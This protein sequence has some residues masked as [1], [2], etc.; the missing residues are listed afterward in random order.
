[1]KQIYFLL[2]ITFCALSAQA[3]TPY[4]LMGASYSQDFN[5]LVS[6]GESDLSTMPGWSIDETGGGGNDN[7]SLFANNGGSNSGDTKSYGM[8]STTER[9]LGSVSSGSC[10]SKYGMAMMNM[11]GSGI[12]AIGITYTGEQWR[13]GSATR[14]DPDTLY[15]EYSLNASDMGDTSATWIAVPAL[16]FL[17]IQYNQMAS[18]ALDGNLAANKMNITGSIP[19]SLANGNTIHLRWRDNN[20]YSSDD[21]LAIDDFSLTVS[22]TGGPLPPTALSFDPADNAVNIDPT[23]SSVVID[24]DQAV[25]AGTGDITIKNLTDA[26]QQTIAASMATFSGTE[27]TI[28]GVMLSSQKDYAIQID[29]NSFDAS[30]VKYLGIYNDTQWNFST[31]FP[32]ALTDL[33]QI[34]SA[35]VVNASVL[36][37]KLLEAKT[38]SLSL[39]DINGRILSKQLEDVGAGQN[40]IALPTA[41]F[42]AGVYIL[43][44]EGQGAMNIKFVK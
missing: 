3:Q 6:S 21:G 17:S 10:Q 1:M 28:P 39:I 38:L 18:N 16:D 31:G 13:M 42:P 8:D 33:D 25:T 27:A 20:M 24:F 41:S 34:E 43:R 36:S 11:T 5:T 15:F 4:N 40:S 23:I 2:A 19:V 35:Y 7:D 32:T 9:A 29:S 22:T 30:G 12:T 14:V 44:I 26:T 37:I